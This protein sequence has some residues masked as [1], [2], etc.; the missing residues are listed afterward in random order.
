MKTV[1]APYNPN[2]PK[3]D[4]SYTKP[5]VLL[6]MDQYAKASGLIW[7]CAQNNIVARGATPVEAFEKLMAHFE[8][9]H[10]SIVS[11]PNNCRRG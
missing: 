1:S 9:L 4:P 6:H 5:H 7:T 8:M 2:G 3:C 11:R 10:S